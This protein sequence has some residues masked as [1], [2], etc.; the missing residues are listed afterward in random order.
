VARRDRLVREALRDRYIVTLKSGATFDGLLWDAD[1][2]TFVLV[3][4]DSVAVSQRGDTLR[5]PVDGS[6]YLSRSDVDYMQ[7]PA[8]VAAL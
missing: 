3:D 6:L 5:T 4:A 1:E 2:A 7:H 8:R